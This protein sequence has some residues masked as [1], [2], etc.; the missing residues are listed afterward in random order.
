MKNGLKNTLVATIALIGLT[1][2]GANACDFYHPCYPQM[3]VRHE[4]RLP[5]PPPP[6]C[7]YRWTN[8]WFVDQWGNGF[9]SKVRVPVC[10]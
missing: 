7:H 9:W 4:V 3:V 1:S 5:P 10:Y 8:Q 6:V 2:F